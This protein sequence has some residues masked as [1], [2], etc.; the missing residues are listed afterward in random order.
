MSDDRTLAMLQGNAAFGQV[1]GV[2]EK[3]PLV[4][5]LAADTML[6][7]A[8]MTPKKESSYSVRPAYPTS[9]HAAA[10]RA[11]VDYLAADQRV[12]TVLLTN[13]CARGKAS[14][15]SCLDIAALVRPDVWEKD[16][17][18]MQ[19]AWEKF[20]RSEGVFRDLETAGQ[21]AEV[22]F[23]FITGQFAPGSR[24][25][26]SP[27]DSFE[28]EI[29][30][31]LVYTHPLFQCS[32]YWQSLRA[33]WLPYY[34]DVLRAERLTISRQH[35]LDNLEHIPLYVA[36]GLYFQSLDRLWLATQDFLQG[37]FIARRTYPIAYNK[38]IRE[39][40]VDILGL[41][42]LYAQLTMLFEI[43]HFESDELAFKADLL[44]KLFEKYVY[45]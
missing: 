1:L 31:Y 21:F 33:H 39:Q 6:Y 30:N 16:G 4:H 8:D 19:E 32:D 41:P 37:L 23:D 38:W 35:G 20:R 36:R 40:I 29:G 13:S 43:K 45:V 27:P 42:E 17:V 9:A 24:D 15:D 3:L 28:I 34:D 18:A 11:I 2:C 7:D 26:V 14:K 5:L 22:H 25:D 10:A 12:E 44:R